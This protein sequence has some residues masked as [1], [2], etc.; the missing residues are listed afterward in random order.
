[1]NWQEYIQREYEKSLYAERSDI[2][3][4]LP[5]LASL[6]DAERLGVEPPELD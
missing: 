3:E 2:K 1:M 4:H 6:A 5:I